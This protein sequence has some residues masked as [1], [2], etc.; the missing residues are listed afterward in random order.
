MLFFGVFE[1]KINLINLL[2]NFDDY[3]EEI[4]LIN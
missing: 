1:I 3:W 4:K 2:I